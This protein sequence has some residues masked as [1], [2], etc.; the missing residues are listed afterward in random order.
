MSGSSWTTGTWAYV[1][2]SADGHDEVCR[3]EGELYKTA[4][5]SISCPTCS[6]AFTLSVRNSA[7]TGHCGTTTSMVDGSLDGPIGQLAFAPSHDFYSSAYPYYAT[8]TNVL[9]WQFPAG[10]VVYTLAWAAPDVP[11]NGVTGSSSSGESYLRF[12]GDYYYYY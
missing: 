1:L 4:S 7:V 6:W 12:D 5:S 9:F 8:Y 3:L 11:H 2:V 10:D